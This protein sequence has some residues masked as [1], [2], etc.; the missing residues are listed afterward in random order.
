MQLDRTHVAIR[1]R[2]LSE[3]GDLSLVMIR[4]YPKA[5]FQAFFLGAAFWIVADLLLLGWLPLQ[6][7]REDVFGDDSSGDQFRY[8]FWMATLVFLQAPIAGALTTYTLGQSIFE[9]QISLRKAIR[10]VRP[11]L[12]QLIRVLGIRRLAIPA[13]IVVGLRW[14]AATD[15]FVDFFVPVFLLVVVALIRS[16][17]PFVAE[18]ILLERCPLRSKQP[19]VITLGRRSKA[20]HS[21]M[22][23][24]LGGRFLTVSMTLTMLLGCVFFALLWMRGM[25]LGNWTADSFA[26]L[27]FYPLALWLV[28]SL[29]VVMKLLGYLDARIRLEGWEVELA[30]RA[31]AI[32][33][34]GEDSM[35]VV[36][37][38]RTTGASHAALTLPDATVITSETQPNEG[39]ND[40]LSQDAPSQVGTTQAAASVPSVK[41]L[42]FWGACVL[43]NL[44]SSPP[45][46][47]A[48]RHAERVAA[49]VFSV[50]SVS[51]RPVVADSPW[52]DSERGEL[53]SIE[54]RDNRVDSKNRNS[55][56]LPEPTQR[57]TK[58][59][60]SQSSSASTS[61][62]SS[63]GVSYFIGWTLL[64]A[65]VCGLVALLLYVFA[66]SSFDFR[67]EMPIQT[68]ASGGVL[69]EQTKQ[70]IAELPAELRGTS[71]SPRAELERLRQT[72]DFDRAI[73]F[74]FGHQLLM[75][76]RVGQIRLSRWK[77]NNQYVRETMQSSPPMGEQLRDTVAAF[78]RSYFGKHPLTGEQFERLWQAN[79]EME[80][81]IAMYG[82]T[83]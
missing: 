45:L 20:L 63:T 26:L 13:M 55:R 8:L 2:T 24:E 62:A 61:P 15:V 50:A 69:D 17:R 78:E 59:S 37:Q 73:I 60:N 52:F 64:I 38:P 33:Q 48:P 82:V 80:A 42:A 35:S 57:P 4:R 14:G 10:E 40:D 70:R 23:S 56:W 12:W 11:V 32:R 16:S 7:P 68:M 9:Q 51:E 41:T 25:A 54:L 34:F 6:S 1:V 5:V 49:D 30:I 43:A 47:A 18:M 67:N 77:T 75:L 28:A 66:N 22:A 46:N 21:P 39:A 74:L 76:D 44:A 19:E 81:T 3:I 31:E 72:G 65:I 71:V 79:L 58:P 29:S 53:R 27:V 83:A 36:L